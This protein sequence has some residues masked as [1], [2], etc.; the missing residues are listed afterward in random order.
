MT[1]TCWCLLCWALQCGPYVYKVCLLL[2]TSCRAVLSH[3]RGPCSGQ[4]AGS[5]PPLATSLLSLSVV[6]LAAKVARNV[7]LC[8]EPVI[9]ATHISHCLKGC[10]I[11][12]TYIFLGEWVFSFVVIEQW[13]GESRGLDFEK[14]SW[15]FPLWLS[16][17]RIWL[18]SMRMWVWS[19]PSL[20]GLRIWR[21]LW[22]MMWVAD[23]APIFRCCECVV[24]RQLQ[25]RFNPQFGNFHMPQ[26]R[27]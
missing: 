26:V 27:L 23:V 9:S 16:G 20:S 4:T 19:L 3:H 18:V 13:R 11:S 17:L 22:A 2:L 25:L 7:I 6:A 24:G 14:A 5:G 1:P 15:E 10:R 21:L 12:R 8:P